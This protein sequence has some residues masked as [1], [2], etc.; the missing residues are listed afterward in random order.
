VSTIIKRG[1]VIETK[2]VRKLIPSKL[3]IEVYSYLNKHYGNLVSEE[4][5][6]QLQQSMDEI[7]QGRA[8]YEQV[9]TSLYDE[10]QAIG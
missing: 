10:I 8:L 1:Y 4:R 2:R 7:E 9:L 6:R 5:T 3:G